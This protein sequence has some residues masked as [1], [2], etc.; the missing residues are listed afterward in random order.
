MSLQELYSAQST[1][2]IPSLPITVPWPPIAVAQHPKT[3]RLCMP[4][5]EAVAAI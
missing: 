5:I 4:D 3:D 2:V 1:A